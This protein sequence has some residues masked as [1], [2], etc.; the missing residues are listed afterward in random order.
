MAIGTRAGHGSPT[1]P[2]GVCPGEWQKEKYDLKKKKYFK[3]DIGFVF[4]FVLFF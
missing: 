1:I 4:C 3:F 2:P